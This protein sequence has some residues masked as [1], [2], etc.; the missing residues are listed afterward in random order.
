MRSNQSSRRS[1]ESSVTTKLHKYLL[2]SALL[3]Y[4]SALIAAPGILSDQ[5]LSLVFSS[6]PNIMLLLDDSGSMD[7]DQVVTNAAQQEHGVTVDNN[8]AS[9]SYT[10]LENNL[11]LRALCAGYNALAFDPTTEYFPWQK[12]LKTSFVNHAETI[13]FNLKKVKT[14]LFTSKSS[15]ADVDLTEHIYI[16]WNDKAP[17]DVYQAGEC[18]PDISVYDGF[19]GSEAVDSMPERTNSN[20]VYTAGYKKVID[21]KQGVITDSN[22]NNGNYLRYDEGTLVID[23]PGGGDSSTTDKITFTLIEFNV[24]RYAGDTDSLTVYAGEGTTG[25]ANTIQVTEEYITNGEPVGVT[26]SAVTSLELNKE[27]MANRTG[28]IRQFTVEGSTVTLV[29]DGG[30]NKYQRSGFVIRWQHTSAPAKVGD[31]LVTFDDCGQHSCQRVADLPVTATDLPVTATG[32]DDKKTQV[33][34]ANWYTYYRT[35]LSVAK[36]GLSDVVVNALPYRVGFASLNDN[37]YGGAHVK[38][39]ADAEGG[40]NSTNRGELLEKIYASRTVKFKNGST[41]KFKN[42]TLLLKGLSNVGRYFTEKK[43]PDDDFFG[44]D[45]ENNAIEPTHIETGTVTKSPI[46]TN[47]FEG[48]C[49]QNY[50]LVFTDGE[51]GDDV[52]SYHGSEHDIN[53]D[54]TDANETGFVGDQDS[55]GRYDNSIYRDGEP[56][57]LADVAMYYFENDLATSVDD[58]LEDVLH[59]E[60][61][62]KQHMKT[63]TIGF[64]VQGEVNSMPSTQTLIADSVWI[65]KDGTL[66]KIDDLRHAAFNGRG[67]YYDATNVDDLSEKLQSFAADV[68]KLAGNSAAGASVS[69]FQLSS[70]SFLYSTSYE[71]VSWS[72]DLKAFASDGKGFVKEVSWSADARMLAKGTDRNITRQIITYNGEKGVPFAF[73]EDYTNMSGANN[74]SLLQA[75]DLFTYAPYIEDNAA[76][77]STVDSGE[78]GSNQSYGNK[79]VDYLRGAETYDG[80]S[81]EGRAFRDRGSKLIGAMIHSQPVYVGKPNNNYI[82]ELE[83]KKYSEFVK[84]NEKRSPVLYVGA[85]DGML[86]GFYADHSKENEEPSFL[87]GDEVFAYIPTMISDTQNGGKGLHK[88]PLEEFEGNAYVDGSSVAADVYVNSDKGDAISFNDPQWR[89]YLVGGL[90][91]GGKGVYVLNVTN[92]NSS[93]GV[94]PRLDQAQQTVEAK[95]IVVNEFTHD[96]LGHVYGQPSIGKMNNGRWATIVSNGYNSSSSDDSNSAAALFIIYLDAPTDP[97]DNNGIDNEGKG[98]FTVLTAPS[99]WIKCAD[100][101]DECALPINAQVRFVYASTEGSTKEYS[102]SQFKHLGDYTCNGSDFSSTSDSTISGGQC[103][104]SDSNGLSSA[105]VVDLDGNGTVD[106]VYAGDLHGNIW[107]FD[108][109][110][111]GTNGAKDWKLHS[112]DQSPFFTAC[113]ADLINGVCPYDHRQPIT[114]KPLVQNHPNQTLGE[115]YPDQLVSFGTGQYLIFIDKADQSLQSFYTVWDTGPEGKNLSKTS[116]TKQTITNDPGFDTR[117]TSSRPVVYNV[118]TST[119]SESSTV[120]FGWYYDNLPGAEKAAAEPGKVPAERVI[121]PT[122]AYGSDLLFVTNIPNKGSCNV[123]AGISYFMAVDLL[124]GGPPS[125]SPFGQDSEGS[126]IAGRR[127]NFLVGAGIV[128]SETGTDIILTD[129]TG[130]TESTTLKANS[131]SDKPGGLFSNKGRKSWSILR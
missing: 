82:D 6:N 71:S 5:P 86:H 66:N 32:D 123:V 60:L 30:Q 75:Q 131:P 52:A 26:P 34:Y 121:L 130:E 96:K 74:I 14:P 33:N 37:G 38:N 49:Q 98:D 62:T 100:D 40:V 126:N 97:I 50:T 108:V 1:R 20:G 54:G 2:S 109:S 58:K 56:D 24:D 112:S 93:S 13:D 125:I 89:T 7:S 15:T 19:A 84:N 64:G 94:H 104:Y 55:N 10:T 115:A 44:T 23:V 3:M 87:G 57:T 114:T 9:L 73:P 41:V 4:S 117:T 68:G 59:N 128:E 80:S 83:A 118:P 69:S 70:Q 21:K 45:A 85:N 53:V 25:I 116:L 61:I 107:I 17:L 77:P 95:K 39:M 18:G 90:R 65:P 27:G 76:F 113:S 36:K 119:S 102:E 28:D 22:S 122:L 43:D 12:Y 42:D 81:V 29:F 105:E 124:T 120:G 48:Q 31:G 111:S 91:A 79:L 88:F 51:W 110:H 101:G 8:G 63:Y 67:K 92:P 46:F 78:I 103:E 47:D 127:E 72:G 99:S 106:R 16:K 35:R 11:E 129:E